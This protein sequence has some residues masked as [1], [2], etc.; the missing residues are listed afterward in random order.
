MCRDAKNSRHHDVCLQ[1]KSTVDAIKF[2]LLSKKGCTVELELRVLNDDSGPRKLC[3]DKVRG[4]DKVQGR[5]QQH[6][7]ISWT[8]YTLFTSSLAPLKPLIT[9][10]RK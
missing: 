2:C 4:K 8:T 5:V 9:C 10:E 6:F 7:C 1:K 3:E